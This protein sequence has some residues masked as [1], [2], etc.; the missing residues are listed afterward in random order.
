[1][2]HSYCCSVTI[3]S[4]VIIIDIKYTIEIIHNGGLLKFDLV[5]K[6][7]CVKSPNEN[8]VVPGSAQYINTHTHT[9]RWWVIHNTNG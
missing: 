2:K 1:M 6:R 8:K 7:A 4:K 9:K 5:D 3:I